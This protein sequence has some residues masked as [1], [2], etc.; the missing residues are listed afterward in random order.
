[1]SLKVVGDRVLIRPK[2]L[3]REH[4]A[5][6]VKIALAYGDMEKAHKMASQEGTIVDIGPE[7]W[8]D[9]KTQWAEVG[10]NV[11]FAQYSGKFVTDP[12]TSEDFIVVNDI[13]VQVVIKNAD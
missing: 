11:I 10:D 5:G 6:G 9:Y 8:G 2:D 1:M 3:K 7:A 4:D 13:D 12:E